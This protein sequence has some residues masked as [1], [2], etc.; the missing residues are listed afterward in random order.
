MKPF[1][2]IDITVNPDNKTQNGRDFLAKEPSPYLSQKFKDASDRM[3]AAV[4]KS[5]L[6]DFLE[7]IKYLCGAVG[8]VILSG[9]VLSIFYGTLKE[10]LKNA[11]AVYWVGGICLF[12]AGML[13]LAGITKSHIVLKRESSQDALADTQNTY[14]EIM[15]ELSVPADAPMVDVIFCRYKTV[16]GKPQVSQLP[17]QMTSFVN[18]AYRIFTDNENLYLANAGGKYAF[19][20][21]SLQTIRTI[22][23]DASIPDWHK[24]SSFD[25]EEYKGYSIT[26]DSYGIF[27][28]TPYYILMLEKDGEIWGIY[29]PNY[30]LPTFEK[31]TGLKAWE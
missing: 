1:L 2:G 24:D 22:F 19:P 11:P 28:T 15:A 27:H 13:Y 3:V 26:K 7:F 8:I 30:E 23:E 4:K 9:V 12:I 21:N 20:V 16:Y 29:F 5:K 31:L 6:P 18:C 10:G 17:M 14:E 25:S